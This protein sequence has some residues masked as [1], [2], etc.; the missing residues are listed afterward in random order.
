MIDTTRLHYLFYT[1]L[2]G[3]VRQASERLDVAPSTISRQI[4]QLE[5]ELGLTLMQRQ[6]RGLIMNDI[7]LSLCEYYRTQREAELGLQAKLDGFRNSERSRIRLSVGEGFVSWLMS[8]PI[9]EFRAAFPKVELEVM[10][11]ATQESVHA[12]LENKSDIAITYFAPN[13]PSL[14]FHARSHVPVT[15]AMHKD[16]PLGQLGRSLR[17]KD[18]ADYPVVLL[19]DQFGG[20]HITDLIARTEQITLHPVL[21][22]NSYRIALAYVAMGTAVF[23]LP[24]KASPQRELDE[25]LMTIPLD[26]P[27]QIISHTQ[28]ITRR[29]KYL[30]PASRDLLVRLIDKGEFEEVSGAPG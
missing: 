15:V 22:A 12:L 17:L 4:A 25:R 8:G 10:I 16:H 2:C 3:G 27:A 6:G 13:D 11:H 20:R 23:L 5:A 9:P 18:V 26:Y 14:I 24:Y 29:G 21:V 1:H 30:G 7:G 28:V 19:G